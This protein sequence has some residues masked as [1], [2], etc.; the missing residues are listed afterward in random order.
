[1]SEPSH[2]RSAENVDEAGR[3]FRAPMFQ[4]WCS[5]GEAPPV[6]CGAGFLM[7]YMNQ[8]KGRTMKQLVCS[9]DEFW[10]LDAI[11]PASSNSSALQITIV[12]WMRWE[13]IRPLVQHP[14]PL[15]NLYFSLYPMGEIVGWEGLSALSH[16]TLGEGWHRQNKTFLLPSSV[17]LF[18]D[19]S[20]CFDS[21]LE[22]STG[23]PDYYKGIL[24]CEWLL[25]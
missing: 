3:A 20:F 11:L 17:Y 22:F 8:L 13:R 23:L 24:I 25:K 12:I 16:T 5:A 21:A 9:F 1:M 15:E 19:F 6:F 18:L 7:M 10:A 14:V 4:F 2:R